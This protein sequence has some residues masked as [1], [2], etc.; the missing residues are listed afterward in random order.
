VS[1]VLYDMSRTSSAP[2]P[3]LKHLETGLF[4]I[5]ALLLAWW[6]FATSQA[7]IYQ[8]VQSARLEKAIGERNESGPFKAVAARAGSRASGLIGKIE[9]PRLELSAIISEGVEEGTLKRAVGH[10]PHTAFPGEAGNVGL[11]GHR[12]SFF[13]NLKDVTPSDTILITTPDGTFTYLIDTTLIVMPD[14]G[15]LLDSTAVPTVT[16]VTC[17]PFSYWGRAP[18][19]FVVQARQLDPGPGASASREAEAPAP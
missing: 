12:D 18:K 8:K 2:N 13:R 1:P 14:R 19:R 6:L 7:V 3:I 5:S 11:A 10:V 16:L 15:D 4:T 17:Y 9:I